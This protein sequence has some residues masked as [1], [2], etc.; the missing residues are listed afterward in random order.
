[1]SPARQKLEQGVLDRIIGYHMVRAQLTTREIYFQAVG[2]P[3]DLRPVE[4]TLLMLL[5][6]N[7]PLTPKQLASALALTAPNLTALLDK[8]QQRGVIERQPSP[9]DK[10]SQLIVLSGAGQALAQDALRRSSAMENGLDGVLSAGERAI[11]L[12]LL[13]K[14]AAHRVE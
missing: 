8:M 7:P 11:L 6:S 2:Q 12:E 14:V 13:K 10:R 4:Y 5:H 3:L 9:T 1:M